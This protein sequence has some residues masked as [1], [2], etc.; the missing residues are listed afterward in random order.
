MLI[1]SY[2]C[3]SP[4]TDLKLQLATP[5]HR[6]DIMTSM[7]CAPSWT[8]HICYVTCLETVLKSNPIIKSLRYLIARLLSCSYQLTAR[9]WHLIMTFSAIHFMWCIQYKSCLFMINTQAH[10]QN[11]FELV[12][13]HPN[14]IESKLNVIST[15]SWNFRFHVLQMHVNKQSFCIQLLKSEGL[16]PLRSFWRVRATGPFETDM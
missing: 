14:A 12:Q 10:P 13:W 9:Y 7:S 5:H 16:W 2:G 4:V 11:K 8:V 6:D 15:K 3:S 1:F